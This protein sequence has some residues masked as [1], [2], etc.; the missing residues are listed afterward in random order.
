MAAVAACSLACSGSSDAAALQ[1]AVAPHLEEM[2]AYDRWARRVALADSAFRS[3]AALEEAAFAPLRGRPAVVAA[4][5]RREGPDPHELTH[6]RSA[7]ELPEAW[8]RVQSSE[9][10]PLEVQRATL[11]IEGVERPCVVVRRSGPAP[12]GATLHV[13][14]AFAEGASAP[15]PAAR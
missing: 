9:L 7:P 13:T 6:P 1:E 4:W 12:G 2:A 10:G 11:R 5:L 14:L 15:P 8:T 3:E